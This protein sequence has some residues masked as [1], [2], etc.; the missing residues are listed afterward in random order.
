[1]D[2]SHSTLT[3][4]SN[5]SDWL[6]SPN[7]GSGGG[8][9]APLGLGSGFFNQE[10]DSVE[11]ITLDNRHRSMS[12]SKG[13]VV[14][15]ETPRTGLGIPTGCCFKESCNHAHD[16]RLADNNDGNVDGST[17][18]SGPESDDISKCIS[19]LSLYDLLNSTTT[20]SSSENSSS[21][22]SDG[23][24]I[25]V[26]SDLNQQLLKPV[27]PSASASATGSVPG[28]G[29][30]AQPLTSSSSATAGKLYKQTSHPPVIRK[31]K[32]SMKL[33]SSSSQSSISSNKS[34]RF[35]SELTK[36]K[37]FDSSREPVTISNE[38]SPQVYPLAHEPS[39]SRG[40]SISTSY[41]SN[42]VNSLDPSDSFWFG[43]QLSKMNLPL[44]KTIPKFSLS[45]S[46]NELDESDS[47]LEVDYF[48]HHLK[49]NNNQNYMTYNGST[50]NSL[51]G[52]SSNSN[53]FSRNGFKFKTN[54]SSSK[55]SVDSEFYNNLNSFNKEHRF[56]SNNSNNAGFNFNFNTSPTK[57]AIQI[58]SWILKDTN[59]KKFHSTSLD[60]KLDLTNYLQGNNIKLHECNSLQLSQG[61]LTGLIYVTNL[62]F[63]KFIEIKFSFNG[64]KDIHYVTATYKRTITDTIDE[65]Q[66][67]INLSSFVYFLK[68]K[69]LILFNSMVSPLTVHLCCRYDVNG[70]TY[71]DN[72]NYE[73]YQVSLDAITNVNQKAK[74]KSNRHRLLKSSTMMKRSLSS[75][76]FVTTGSNKCASLSPATSSTDFTKST[77]PKLGRRFSEDTDFF[78]SSPLKNIQRN[79]TTT[80]L[81]QK[82]AKYDELIKSYCFYNPSSTSKPLDVNSSRS[83]TNIA[84]KD[85]DTLTRPISCAQQTAE[86]TN[87]ILEK[88][89]M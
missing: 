50:G 48:N 36:I 44:S 66:F 86:T 83:S 69:N 25:E 40:S 16:S 10:N 17:A 51:P 68:I 74:K 82:D 43:T 22:T 18:N 7:S 61:K 33:S 45:D 5:V 72:N 26:E 39:N 1:M 9:P 75:D 46:D 65:F 64:W 31:L 70:E 12:N 49:D 47:D 38:T 27:A 80:P 53:T 54:D 89:V 20:A 32:S 81:H 30:N 6:S 13:S 24:E 11:T 79:Y 8:S 56:Y 71:Y 62:S 14:N 85:S 76:N 29:I 21:D 59:I 77:P 52:S 42:L 73:N 78:N 58:K 63:E 4:H 84:V 67:V 60:P 55:A 88:G 57:D 87:Q 37:R 23:S 41:A 19:N 2:S 15:Q 34:V 28:S 3:L 35:A